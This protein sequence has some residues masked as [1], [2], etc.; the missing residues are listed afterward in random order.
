MLPKHDRYDYSAIV[1]RPDYT[2]PEGKRLAF[3]F[4]LNI[5]DFAF[6]KG[7]GHSPSPTRK[8]PPP[9]PLSFAWRD[10]GLRVGIWRIF[11]LLDEL[12]LPACHLLNSTICDDYPP[13]IDKIRERGDEVVSHG[14]TNSE[15]QGEFIEKEEAA[16]IREAT[17]TLTRC[18]DTKP[19]GWPC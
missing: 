6:G 11:D 13:I 18:F 12:G 5:E 14:R 2:W 16:L 1:S 9:D 8:E 7:G 3:Y 10:Y 4:A 17:D 15:R 19:E